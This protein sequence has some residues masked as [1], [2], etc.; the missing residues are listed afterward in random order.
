MDLINELAKQVIDAPFWLLLIFA[1]NFI[2]YGLKQ[3]DAL[4]NKVIPLVLMVIG[5]VAMAFL[6]DPGAVTPFTRYPQAMLALQGVIYAFIAWAFHGVIWKRFGI[7]EGQE[8][9]KP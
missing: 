1:L 6:G 3:W 8:E 9:K 5:A 4:P 7:Q 2:G